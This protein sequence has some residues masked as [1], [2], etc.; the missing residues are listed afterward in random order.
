MESIRQQLTSNV[1]ADRR[2]KNPGCEIIVVS[3][4]P[5]IKGQIRRRMDNLVRARQNIISAYFSAWNIE[6]SWPDFVGACLSFLFQTHSF[7]MNYNV[8]HISLRITWD[9]L[10]E[11]VAS[12]NDW[13]VG[14]F[15]NFKSVPKK[16][17][18]VARWARIS[19]CRHQGHSDGRREYTSNRV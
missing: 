15:S 8:D 6:K 18:Y 11:S 3:M 13:L 9:I 16:W 4:A 1:D 14:W 19:K 7:A 17:T 5:L 12:L 10:A 2:W